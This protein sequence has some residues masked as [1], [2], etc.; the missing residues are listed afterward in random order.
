MI[1]PRDSAALYPPPASLE[2][3]EQLDWHRY[4][5]AIVRYKW[6]IGA[7]TVLGLGAGI[8]VA[9]ITKP[10]YQAQGTIW[11]ETADQRS[12]PDRGP[13]RSSE[14]LDAQ[15]WVDLLKSYV[16]LDDV[17]RGLRLYLRPASSSDSTALAT[18]TLADR[19]RPGEYRLAIDDSGKTFTLS[20]RGGVVL[21]QG[22]VGDSVGHALG[23]IWVL[24]QNGDLRGRTIS[25][26]VL[27]PRDA[28]R[29]L[30]TDLL[31]LMDQENPKFIRLS[32][33][34]T[35]PSQVASV[36][37]AIMNRFVE[38]AAELKRAKLTELT[39]ILDV[40]MRSSEQNL[41]TAEAALETFRV[42]TITLPGDRATPVIPGLDATRDP[43]FTDYF[44]MKIELEQVRRDRDAIQRV[45]VPPAGSPE[46]PLASLEGVGAVQR[47]VELSEALKELTTK[48]A[49]LRALR[50]R[51][52][53]AS[54]TVLHQVAEIDSL[55]HRTIPR[56]SEGV[57]QGLADRER[58]LQ[59]RVE[60]AGG[61]LREIPARAIEEAR[62]RR[63]VAIDENLYTTLQQRYQEA[64][65]ADASSI[66]DVRVLDA[67]IPP[68]DPVKD[69]ASR[70]ILMGLI[71]GLA[72][73]LVGAVV[74][75]RIDSRLRYPDQV[76]RELGLP[77]LGALP[78]VK[79]VGNGTKAADTAQIIEALRG[80]RLNLVHA[81]GGAGPLLL[82]IT[83]PGSG[84]GKSFLSSN[85]ALAFGDGGY[86]TLLIDGD[87]RR[88]TLHRLLGGS[89]KPGLT[90]Y[91]AGTAQR[92][93]IVQPTGFPL[94]SF[95][96]S[97]TRQHTS[98]ELLGS[99]A[100][101]ELLATM[102]PTYNV[103]L[104]DSPPLG[105]GIDPFVL[106]TATRNVLLVLRTGTTDKQLA[107]AKLEVLQRLPVHL[108]GAVINDVPEFGMYYRYYSY[109]SG[110][111]TEDE[112]Q[113]AAR[114]L[115]GTT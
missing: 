46:L 48:Q 15:A 72:L 111:E 95:I 17:V 12:G 88:G 16:V 32:L 50:Y 26:A 57:L 19:F 39:K 65:L 23:F 27:T 70:M 81:H 101:P 25:F 64:R 91:L 24:P 59:A 104:V 21:Q 112:Q 2:E 13:I 1:V 31:V 8:G 60:G 18:F 58:V 20:A 80:V 76:T 51:Y 30:A 40:Q 5:S 47:S 90:D 61:E 109:L 4:W 35:Q 42:H 82:T 28:S 33:E 14:L 108:L 98:P 77:I 78:H 56:L 53:D 75:D 100:L 55:E 37:N 49:E 74:L 52:T 36:L 93:A 99:P 3:G 63:Q 73:A 45:L 106:G 113:F 97:G 11:V 92:D 84:D 102:R 10:R 41:R 7:L 68:E 34:G 66:P 22:A 83:S 62:L 103:I 67:A 44:N 85:L 43:V 96:A 87:V 71:G 6:A 114:Q 107:R 89:R 38:V 115:P 110:Y 86:R 105:A 69:T 94:V 9:R 29:K 79:T 54:P